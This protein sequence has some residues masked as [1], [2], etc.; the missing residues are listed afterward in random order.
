MGA[1]MAE[2]FASFGVSAN[3]ITFLT[4][5]LAMLGATSSRKEREGGDHPFSTDIR[6]VLPHRC[7]PPLLSSPLLPALAFLAA[8]AP[9]AVVVPSFAVAAPLSLLSIKLTTPPSASASAYASA[10]AS[11]SASTS[12]SATASNSASATTTLIIPSYRQSYEYKTVVVMMSD[13][14]KVCLH[15]FTLD[16]LNQVANGLEKDSMKIRDGLA[17]GFR[18]SV[19]IPSLIFQEYMHESAT[20]SETEIK[21]SVSDSVA[22]QK[23]NQRRNSLFPSLIP[24]L[25]SNGIRDGIHYSVSDS[26]SD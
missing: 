12:T 1:A 4:G 16:F 25:I 19:A 6:R 5:H 24:F 20:E 14:G 11:A 17:T 13:V 9:L 10:S 26:V 15:M 21:N 8:A 23:R 2:R 22:N 3:L 7:C 18:H